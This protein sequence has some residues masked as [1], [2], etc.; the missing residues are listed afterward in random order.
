MEHKTLEI[1]GYQSNLAESEMLSITT[2][3]GSA[4][5]IKKMTREFGSFLV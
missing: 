3:V 1:A 5:L 4:Q 2:L